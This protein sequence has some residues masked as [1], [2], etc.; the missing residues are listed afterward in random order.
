[1]LSILNFIGNIHKKKIIFLEVIRNKRIHKIEKKNMYV[2]VDVVQ[3]KLL[4][5]SSSFN[6]LVERCI[7]F[8]M[9]F[10]VNISNM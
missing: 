3:T 5:F 6:S 9:N 2:F 8:S 4:I 1:M 7:V 10:F